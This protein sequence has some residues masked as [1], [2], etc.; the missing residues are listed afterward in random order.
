MRAVEKN[1]AVLA[2]E[3]Y[4]S[5]C[6]CE[7]DGPAKDT[8]FHI[9]A[10]SARQGEGGLGLEFDIHQNESLRTHDWQPKR[11]TI[12]R[13]NPDRRREPPE[14][15]TVDEASWL[16]ISLAAGND[17]ILY[18]APGRKAG[19]AHYH[20]QSATPSDLAGDYLASKICVIFRTKGRYVQGSLLTMVLDRQGRPTPKVDRIAASKVNAIRRQIERTQRT[21]QPARGV[22]GA[23][24]V[25]RCPS[26]T[27]CICP[28]QSDKAAK[29]PLSLMPCRS[30]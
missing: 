14:D 8:R 26:Y 13:R 18:W 3:A 25:A 30:A 28:W 22:V 6:L 2:T 29:Q 1:S 7:E 9:T 4:T 27:R 23:L 15:L 24:P 11:K 12:K 21:E 5:I 10:V 16:L 20:W 17:P 19:A